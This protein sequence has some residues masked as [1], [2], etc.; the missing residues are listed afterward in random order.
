MDLTS[1]VALISVFGSLSFLV[2]VITDGV[3]RRRQLQVVSE[4]HNK[5]LERMHTPKE[6]SEFLDSPG[7]A[8]FMDSIAMERT[9]PAH[10]IMRATQVGIVLGAAGIGCRLVGAQTLVDREA[11]EGFLVLGIILLCVGLG[12][13][14]SAAVSYGLSRSLGLFE[15]ETASSSR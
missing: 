9:H 10:R 8:K 11:S 15:A 12:Y 5:L 1:V 13:I 4:F 3:R 2:W 14:V 6:L 7:G